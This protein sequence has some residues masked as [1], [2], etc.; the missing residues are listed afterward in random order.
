[1]NGC[2]GALSIPALA[3]FDGPAFPAGFPGLISAVYNFASLGLI[4]HRG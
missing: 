2:G 4:F 1:M 3:A